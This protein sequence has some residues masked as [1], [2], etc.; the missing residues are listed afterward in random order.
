MLLEAGEERVARR[1]SRRLL[2]FEQ[3]NHTKSCCLLPG[4]EVLCS[5]V[6]AQRRYRIIP[7]SV[8]LI[9][10]PLKAVHKGLV[11]VSPDLVLHLIEDGGDIVGEKGVHVQ[12]EP[13]NGA[14]CE[15]PLRVAG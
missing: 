7:G 14:A 10:V 11:L 3:N 15:E 8:L 13:R 1:A 6:G 12:D 4:Q 2:P 5:A 9:A